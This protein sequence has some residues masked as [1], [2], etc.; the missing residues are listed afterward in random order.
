M[1]KKVTGG[2]QRGL[3]TEQS[4]NVCPNKCNEGWQ[5]R[6]RR[7]TPVLLALTGPPL[8]ALGHTFQLKIAGFKAFG[9]IYLHRVAG[10]FYHIKAFS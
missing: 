6:K 7:F 2:C 1:L 5:R 4:R 3:P 8:S 10:L 9:N